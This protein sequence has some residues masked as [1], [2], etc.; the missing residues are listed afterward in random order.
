MY[1]NHW[2]LFQT[3]LVTDTTP[4]RRHVTTHHK[5]QVDTAHLFGVT[6]CYAELL[7][8]LVKY[9]RSVLLKLSDVADRQFFR[10]ESNIPAVSRGIEFYYCFSLSGKYPRTGR[11]WYTYRHR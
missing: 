6:Y 7:E 9:L 11:R 1:L 5:A 10:L 8:L 3:E 4:T 2:S